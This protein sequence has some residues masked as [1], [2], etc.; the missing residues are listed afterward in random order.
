M[1]SDEQNDKQHE[2]IDYIGLNARDYPHKEALVDSSSKVTYLTAK[3]MSD[4]LALAFMELGLTKG[5]VVLVQLPNVVQYFIVHSALQKSGLVGLNL[6][7]NV[8]SREIEFA[9]SQTNSAAMVIVPA[10]RDFSY[11]E[12]VK[13][14]QSRLP[15]LK[16]IFAVGPDVPSACVS[17]SNLIDGYDQQSYPANCFEQSRIK[18]GELKEIRMTSGTTGFPKLVNVHLRKY[19]LTRQS[20]I[21][22]RF[23]VDHSDVFAALAPLSGGGSGPPC[24]AIAQMCGCK[25]AMLEKYDT[26]KALKLLE[27]E[28]VTF[29][30]GVPAQMSMMVRH[31]DLGKYDLSAL[32]AFYYAGSTIPYAVATEVEQK[33]NCRIISLYG[34]LDA[35]YQF[36]TSYDDPEDVRRRSVG[37]PL[38]RTVEMRVVDDQL[39]EVQ[40]GVV[41][42]LLVREQKRNTYY[43]DKKENV[44]LLD[45]QGWRHT[46]DLGKLDEAGNLY[47]VGRKKDVIIRGGANIYP[48]EIENI[49]VK[50]P[51]VQSVAVV[52][53]PDP[54]MGEKACACVIPK[55]GVSLS[56]DG[57]LSYLKDFDIAKYKMPERLELMDSFPMS[58]D[59][60]K[61]M[62]RELAQYIAAILDAE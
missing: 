59:G 29:A 6:L 62:K 27:S 42:E 19:H 32:R 26:Q 2:P 28:K 51:D 58:G 34:G 17:I 49:L 14:V 45:E 4:R 24:K 46:G 12:M 20:D 15:C 31:P 41:G 10:Y 21:I 50:H 3:Q 1:A 22:N 8:R 55:P 52:A 13:D 44:N 43:S 38:G 25:V 30:T 23:K 36:C 16:H 40:P 56:L 47:I 54:V 61:I 35:G 11:F 18:Q 60:Q 9:V 39:D 48:A 7:M 5:Q 57:I 53:M 37:K 33:L